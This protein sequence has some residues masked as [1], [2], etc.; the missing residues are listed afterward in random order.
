MERPKPPRK[1]FEKRYKIGV[2]ILTLVCYYEVTQELQGEAQA[3]T[4]G[5]EE[6]EGMTESQTRKLIEWL[7]SQGFDSEKIV[8]CLEYI[9][10][11]K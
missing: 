3:S 9:N 1:I 2:D 10:S 8:E 6:M 4:K 11:K 5:S 7:K